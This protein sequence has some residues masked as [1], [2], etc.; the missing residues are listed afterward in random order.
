MQLRKM[1]YEEYL[2]TPE[3]KQ[4]REKVLARDEHR[5]RVCDSDE[6]LQ[7]HHRTYARR[8]GEDL[9]DLTTLCGPCHEHFHERIS[10]EALMIKT[11]S[12]VPE[13]REP[14]KWEDLLI[15]LLL[16]SPS[17]YNHVRDI[18]SADDFVDEEMRQ[19][20]H[21][22]SE[23]QLPEYNPSIYRMLS[24]IAQKYVEDETNQV[25]NTIK[26]AVQIKR[27][28]LTQASKDLSA[29]VVNT[30]D[31]DAI[32]QIQQ[33]IIAIHQQ[34]RVLDSMHGNL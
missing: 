7:V 23:S 8:G 31:R 10:Q 26:I 9:N 18:L 29:Q 5:C 28:R 6:K 14:A 21:T 32:R 3:W 19:I 11:V 30:I 17:L 34:L 12:F 22:F 16:R 27:R 13:E 24:P 33:E 1:P 25:D 2:Q 20:Y 15:A 4:K